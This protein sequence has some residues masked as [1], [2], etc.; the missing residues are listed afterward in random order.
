MRK[1]GNSSSSDSL[2]QTRSAGRRQLWR[3]LPDRIKLAI[4]PR[5]PRVRRQ[6]QRQPLV[7]V[8]RGLRGGGARGCGSGPGGHARLLAWATGF[9]S[10]P[11]TASE[12][13]KGSPLIANTHVQQ[14]PQTLLLIVHSCDG[15]AHCLDFGFGHGVAGGDLTTES[16]ECCEGA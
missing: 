9:P 11:C 14:A 5:V 15:S 1:W 16:Q 3:Q 7:G 12:A 4:V 6:W 13:S 2:A 10:K 8:D